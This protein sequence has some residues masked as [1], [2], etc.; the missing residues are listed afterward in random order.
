[1][2]IL[3]AGDCAPGKSNYSFFKKRKI[4]DILELDL[5][6]KWK[7][8]DIRIFNLESPITN[9]R[10]PII[11]CGPNLSAPASTI[12]GIKQLNPTVVSLGNNHI[13][14][15]GLEG[16]IE[17]IE[18]LN[19]YNIPFVGAGLKKEEAKKHLIINKNDISIGIYSCVENEFSIARENY[20]GANGFDFIET[21][22]DIKLI[23]NKVDYLIVLY[24]GGK[25][26]YRYPSPLLQKSLRHMIKCGADLVVCQH[27]H[28]VSSYEYFMGK[29]ILYGQGNFIFDLSNPNYSRESILLKVFI[30][31]END[32][33]K[34][35]VKY[36]FLG[37]IYENGKVRSA[38]ENEN[39]TI[40]RSLKER[41]EKMLLPGYLKEEYKKYSKKNLKD[42]LYM[43]S[44]L[45]K[46]V[47]RVD[48][49]ILNGFLIKML[50]DKRRLACLL[51]YIKCEAHRELIIEGIENYLKLIR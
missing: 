47:C 15:Y 32:T 24:H 30:N 6:E 29:F 12:E 19:R 10:V 14:D 44:G 45:P 4:E 41:S 7:S 28:I 5:Y 2:L 38:S 37:I 21:Y 8:A 34:L 1:M 13:L 16:L 40:L 27:N 17:T 49:Y 11:K 3:I 20:G 26:Y 48:K 51:N 46:I 39:E 35:T 23:K 36:D 33:K 22:E 9:N 42:Y 43:I 18:L 25:E 50:Y 31:R